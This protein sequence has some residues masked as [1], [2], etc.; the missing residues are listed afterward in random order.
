[1]VAWLR[2][3][4]PHRALWW[5]IPDLHAP[6]ADEAEDLL[7]QLRARL[8]RGDAVLMHCGAG[9]GRA[10][11][12]AAALLMSMGTARG[13]AVALV[14]S[15]RP[16]AGPGAGAAGTGSAFAAGST[17]LANRRMFAS[18]TSSGMPPYFMTHTKWSGPIIRVI[19]WSFSRH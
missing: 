16:M 2:A 11:T 9:I 18:A 5:P 1:Y 7:A 12:I 15:R 17:S 14:A 6:T 13:D 4:A 10:G 19:V 8:D 3:A